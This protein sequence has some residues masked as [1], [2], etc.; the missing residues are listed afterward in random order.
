MN[1][2]Q[3]LLSTAN[4]L[5][6][7]KKEKNHWRSIEVLKDAIRKTKRMRHINAYKIRK[8]IAMQL[9]CHYLEMD[10]SLSALAS[11]TNTSAASISLLFSKNQ[12]KTRPLEDSA[13]LIN[14]PR[15]Y[16]LKNNLFLLIGEAEA[17][18]LGFIWSDGYLLGGKKPEGIRLCL[19]RSDFHHLEKLK[20]FL[21][22]NSP[23]RKTV[24]RANGKTYKTATLSIY[25]RDLGNTL[26][27]MGIVPGRGTKDSALPTIPDDKMRHFLRG[28]I[29]GDGYLKK[30]KTIA[31]HTG[32]EIG[33]CG[34]PKI[35]KLFKNYLEARHPKPAR[36][37][38]NGKS[39]VNLRAYLSGPSAFYAI[40]HFYENQKC[41]LRR[42][43]KI[44]EQIITIK[45]EIKEKYKIVQRRNSHIFKKI[46]KI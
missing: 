28:L 9:H 31:M 38:K 23:I 27:E 18:W 44:A 17:Y 8:E 32:W 24:H 22:S 46:T 45:N 7:N 30:Q 16:T 39:E 15:Q 37:I 25:S 10:L 1:K 34:T 42:K 20:T 11:L 4:D 33:L 13:R 29:D 5:K 14:H 35:T 26:S 3:E 36:I 41:S 12:L 2:E 43:E 19:T 40:C 21:G 6:L